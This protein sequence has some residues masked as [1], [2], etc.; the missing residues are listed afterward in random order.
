MPILTDYD[1]FAGTHWETGTA[2][3]FLAYRGAVAPHTGQPYSEAFLLGVSGGITTGYFKFA[4]EGYDPQCNI[5]TRNTFDPWDRML[6]RL[7]V[8]Q[9][10]EHTRSAERAAALLAD[11]LD[12]GVPAIVWADMWR[13][14]YNALGDA[15]GMWGAMPIL[16]YGYDPAAD[17]ALVADRARVPVTTSASALDAASGRIKKEKFRLVTL[18]PPQEAKLAAAVQAGI[19]DAIKL[20]T[21]KPP[22]G[23]A[24]NFGLAAL[25]HWADTLRK[26]TGRQSWAKWF[27]PGLPLY[28]GLT[29]AYTFAFLFGKDEAQDAERGR[30]ADFLDEAALLL[31]RPALRDAAQAFRDAA[32]LWRQLPALLLPDDVELLGEARAQLWRRHTA[33]LEQGSAALPELTAADERLAALRAQ[34]AA[35]FPLDDTAAAALRERLAAHL[36]R[37]HDAEA[38]AVGVLR[39]AME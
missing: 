4:Y 13:L 5:L 15:E 18:D 24:N 20:F 39:G 25:R 17:E 23:A 29:S 1:Q 37:L 16:V 28:A 14:P 32:A 36:L 38:A 34:A 31:E 27:P 11:T 22:R 26:T 21:E 9:T 10:V 6:S 2:R 30:Y 12:A 33:F 7:G 3:N 19:W 35:A 8:V